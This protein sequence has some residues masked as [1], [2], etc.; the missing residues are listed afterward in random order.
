MRISEVCIRRPVM[1]TLAAGLVVWASSLGYHRPSRA[2]EVPT[3]TVLVQYPG[4]NADTV[5]VSVA[6]PLE[7]Q[8]SAIPGVASVSSATTAGRTTIT[9][10]F[11]QRR[12]RDAAAPAVQS[13]LS[14]ASAGLPQDLPTPAIVTKGGDR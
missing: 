9:I 3:I 10:E 4:A 6:A 8:F 11:D 1:A 14:A 13:A 5:A 12:T 2:G 7:R